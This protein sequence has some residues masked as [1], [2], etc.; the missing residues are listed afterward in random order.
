MSKRP[1]TLARGGLW[2]AEA[3]HIGGSGGRPPGRHVDLTV[4]YSNTNDQVTAMRSKLDTRLAARGS[5]LA[6]E[7][8]W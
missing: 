2:G 1:P 3:P 6:E 8:R 4:A 7:V 5:R